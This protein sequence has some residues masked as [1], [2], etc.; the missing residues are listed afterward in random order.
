MD[1][2]L[3][4]GFDKQ[5]SI[6]HV[7]SHLFSTN[8]SRTVALPSPYYQTD[9][10]Y[11]YFRLPTHLYQSSL[12]KAVSDNHVHLHSELVDDLVELGER[13]TCYGPSEP[14]PRLGIILGQVRHAELSSESCGAV[15]DQVVGG[16]STVTDHVLVSPLVRLRRQR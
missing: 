15:D 9:Q 7:G 14:A 13:T 4:T 5:C 12:I 3:C 10:R 16:H 11:H 6:D 1:S 2:I 8:I